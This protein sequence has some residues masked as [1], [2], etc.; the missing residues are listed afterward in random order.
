ML[1]PIFKIGHKS[2]G[3][4]C[5]IWKNPC[6]KIRYIKGDY[7]RTYPLSLCLFNILLHLICFEYP[8]KKLYPC[9]RKLEVYF[10]EIISNVIKNEFRMKVRIEFLIKT[11]REYDCARKRWI[12]AK[13]YVCM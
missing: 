12:T 2:K 7:L 11:T 5:R 6:G 9:K 4:K 8:D 1:N 10:T 13:H 3:K